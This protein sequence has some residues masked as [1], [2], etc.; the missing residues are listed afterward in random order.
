MTAAVTCLSPWK[1]GWQGRSK[2]TGENIG[3]EAGTSGWILSQKHWDLFQN[4]KVV[5]KMF[6]E[7]KENTVQH[8]LC[9]PLCGRMI[10]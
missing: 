3:N 1:Y 10:M 5:V 8:T 4:G 2:A 7:L 9:M 6:G